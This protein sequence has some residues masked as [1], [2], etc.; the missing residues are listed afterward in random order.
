[1]L[2]VKA[3]FLPSG[4]QNSSDTEAFSP[5]RMRRMRSCSPS[6]S[7]TTGVG[8]LLG[9]SAGSSP[10]GKGRARAG[11]VH[12]FVLVDRFFEGAVLRVLLGVLGT[13]PDEAD[14][15]IAAGRGALSRV[16]DDAAVRRPDRMRF[17]VRV[18]RQIERFRRTVQR[19]QPDVAV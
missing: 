12:L 14:G 2:P 17:V 4:D 16:G 13:E 6:M 11:F 1:M 15:G 9:A 3:S 5:R 19:Q 10:Q 18:P 7:M 8:F